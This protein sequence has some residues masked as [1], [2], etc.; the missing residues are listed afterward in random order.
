MIRRAWIVLVGLLIGGGFY[1]LLIDT[2]DL[3]EL[4]VLAGV[5]P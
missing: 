5:A 3:P 4:Y 1:L 2:N